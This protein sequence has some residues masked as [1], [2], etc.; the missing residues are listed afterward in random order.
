[1]LKLEQDMIEMRVMADHLN[2]NKA[3]FL[4]NLAHDFRTPLNG[5]L[6]FAQLLEEEPFGPIG[7]DHY[8]TYVASIR[9][10]AV[11]LNDRIDTCLD[12]EKIEFGAEPMQMMPFELHAAVAKALPV[13]EAMAGSAGIKV[14]TDIPTELPEI[15]GDVR[16]LK[17]ILINLATSAIKH[18][19]PRGKVRISAAMTADGAL[20]LQVEDDGAGLDMGLIEALKHGSPAAG[21]P[22]STDGVQGA[23]LFVVKNLAEMHDARLDILN[24]LRS[25]T[26][27]T[28]T[29]PAARLI[30]TA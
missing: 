3:L 13:I 20:A 16:A 25:G 10:S 15:H 7:N 22:I 12:P 18:T 21:N 17:K 6:G 11:M 5:I 9:E 24:G 19:G 26:R 4:S 27:V 28:V 14:E 23:G 29:F 8:K 30:Q 1:R 2:D